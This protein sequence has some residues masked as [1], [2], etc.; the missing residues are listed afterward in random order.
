[1]IVG[2]THKSKKCDGGR[3]HPTECFSSFPDLFLNKCYWTCSSR[4]KTSLRVRSSSSLLWGGQQRAFC[5]V[6][7][8]LLQNDG[9]GDDFIARVNQI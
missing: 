3:F 2:D 6:V 5:C 8:R 7:R 1:M 4:R 9:Y